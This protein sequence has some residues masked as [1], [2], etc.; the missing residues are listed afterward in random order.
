MHKYFY[1]KISFMY[2]KSVTEVITEV[3][4]KLQKCN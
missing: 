2:N 1:V 4:V 3:L